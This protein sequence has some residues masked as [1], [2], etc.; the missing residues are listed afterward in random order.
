M[1]EDWQVGDLA[2]CVWGERR[3]MPIPPNWKSPCKG[4]LYTVVKVTRGGHSLGLVLTD[5][6]TDNPLG[7]LASCFRKIKPLTDEEREQFFAEL[8]VREVV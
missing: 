8:N 6:H 2:L 5:S 3:S 4:G 1:A 7:W